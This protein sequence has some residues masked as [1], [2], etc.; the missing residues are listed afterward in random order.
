M[1]TESW[2]KCRVHG[3]WMDAEG[4]RLPGSVVTTISARVT[5]TVENAIIPAGKYM[6]GCVKLGISASA[7]SLDFQ[8]PATDDPDIP[9]VGWGMTVIV[10]FDDPRIKSETYVL[11]TI[12]SGG[13]IDLRTIIPTTVASPLGAA[14]LKVGRPGGVALLNADGVVVNADGTPIASSGTMTTLTDADLEI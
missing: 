6:P 1:A 14:S 12:P 8:C 7:P 13:V 10:T 2:S 4:N 3:T 9:E 5:N 11:D